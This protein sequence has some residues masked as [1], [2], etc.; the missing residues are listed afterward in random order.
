MNN[1][2]EDT[3]YDYRFLDYR[4]DQL[5]LNLRKGQ[6][7]LEKEYKESNKTILETLTAM[8]EGQN[9]QN[10][11]IVEL[12]QRQKNVEEKMKCIDKLKEVATKN[13]TKV[14]ELERRIDIYKQVLVGVGISAVSALVIGVLKFI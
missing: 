5:E 10:R 6:E 11:T 8:Q 14:H 13:T 4:L 12:I 9:E 3:T 7:K 2:T 1:E